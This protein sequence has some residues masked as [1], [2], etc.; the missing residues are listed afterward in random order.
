MFIVTA[1]PKAHIHIFPF[2]TTAPVASSTVGLVDTQGDAITGTH[3]I[4]VKTPSAA[5]VA[6]ATAGLAGH[7]HIPKHAILSIGTKLVM[8]A[9]GKLQARTL[10]KGR[11]LSGPGATPNEHLHTAPFT[12]NMK[13]SKTTNS[14]DHNKATAKI[15]LSIFY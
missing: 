9:T 7:E 1:P 10:F 3:G 14:I 8:L 15:L 4:G 5:A 13:Q 12:A 11:M 2:M 6:A